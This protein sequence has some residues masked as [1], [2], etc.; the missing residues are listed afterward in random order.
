M[1]LFRKTGA[2]FSNCGT[3]RYALWREWDTNLPTILFLMLN[4]SIANAD[5]NDPTAERCERR[6]TLLGY[7]RMDIRNLFA[8]VSTDPAGLKQ[9]ADPVGPDNDVAIMEAALAAD[10][11]ICAWGKNGSLLN[12]DAAVITM[13]RS[14]SI[15]PKCL[16]ITP[17]SGMPEHPLYIPYSATP[18][19]FELQGV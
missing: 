8:L 17:K 13:L 19:P 11:T 3:Y 7:G 5:S 12:R 2:R 4:P 18:I 16:R 6:A 15:Q 1:D 10:L 9:H 14:A